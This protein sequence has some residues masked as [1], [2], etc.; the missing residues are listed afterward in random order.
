MGHVRTVCRSR[1]AAEP[2]RIGRRRT[3][4]PS[5]AP[6]TLGVYS[7][8]RKNRLV[9]IMTDGT[10]ANDL[11]KL[12]K[13]N[14]HLHLTGSMRPTTLAELAERYG[15]A[16]PPALTFAD[17]DRVYPWSM[18]Q[19]RYDAARAVIT[20]ADD[21]RRVAAEAFEDNLADGC[22]WVELQVDPTSYAPLVGGLE[23]VVEAVLDAV[24]AGRGGVIVASSWARPGEHAERLAKLAGRYAD[25][26]VIGFG[27]SN[28]ERAGVVS[29][30]ATAFRIATDAGLLATPHAGCYEQAWHVRACVEMLNAR[31]IGHGVTAAADP[32]TVALLAERQVAMEMCPTSYP[33]LG[34][35]RWTDLQIRALLAAG[36]PVALGSDDPLLFGGTVTDQYRIVRQHL[37]MSD[38]ELATLARHSVSASAA[39]T[40]VKDRIRAGIDGWLAGPIYVDHP[41]T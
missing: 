23:P 27:V 7:S 35:A 24:P 31:R 13:T 28:D 17:G 41:D 39:P 36:V 38:V 34:I 18:F 30:F 22:D 40:A 29:K 26:G 5:R 6:V 21:I 25:S 32:S 19:Q 3:A 8:E 9:Q 33:P 1:R 2:T 16:V 20:G 10:P 11:Q 37:G 12:P 15:V 14:L 4:R